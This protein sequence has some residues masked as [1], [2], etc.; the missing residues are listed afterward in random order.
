MNNIIS[1]CN[2]SGNGK[3]GCNT[4]QAQP[5]PTKS[6]QL[7][8]LVSTGKPLTFSVPFLD[9]YISKYLSAY[10]KLDSPALIGTPTAPIVYDVYDDSNQIATTAFVQTVA[11]HTYDTA[12]MSPVF[13]GTITLAPDSLLSVQ[14]RIALSSTAS[15]SLYLNSETDDPLEIYPIKWLY[16]NR[17]TSDVQTQF[18]QQTAASDAI[19]AN[20]IVNQQQLYNQYGNTVI[21]QNNVVYLQGEIDALYGNIQVNQSGIASLYGNASVLQVQTTGQTY[22]S[23]NRQTGFAGNLIVQQNAAVVGATTLTGNVTATTNLVVGGALWGNQLPVTSTQIGYLTNV[24]ADVQGQLNQLGANT[25]TQTYDPA[26]QTTQFSR[27]V[28]VLGNVDVVG[29][30][31]LTGN[32]TATT[33]LVVGGALWGNQLPVTSTQIGY[34]TNVAADVQGQLNQLGANTTTQTYDP[35]SQTTQF[36]RN[37]SVLGNVAVAGN[38][39][40]VSGATTLTGNVTAT[41]NLVVG[42][43]LWGNQL[44]VTS[45]QIG[46]LTGLTSDVQ[47]QLTVL[48]TKTA[49]Q[50]YDVGTTT[51]TF[52]HHVVTGG[53]VHVGGNVQMDRNVVV[54]GGWTVTSTGQATLNATVYLN[55]SIVANSQ[56]VTSTQMGYLSGL[57]SDAQTQMNATALATTRQTHNL[58]TQTTTWTGVNVTVASADVNGNIGGGFVVQRL[59]NSSTQYGDT[60]A[61]TMGT[62]TRNCALGGYALYGLANGSGSYN[63]AV[64]SSSASD[65]IDGVGGTM[66]LLTNGSYNTATGFGVLK[67]ISGTASYNT[68]VGALAFRLAGSSSQYNTGIGY[69]AGTG[70][71]TLTGTQNT[72]LGANSGYIGDGATATSSTA[73]GYGATIQASH[74]IVLGTSAEYVD[75]A[76]NLVVRNES[77]LQKVASVVSYPTYQSLAPNIG[78]YVDY[79]SAASSSRCWINAAINNLSGGIGISMYIDQLPVT[80]NSSYDLRMIID[81]D[82]YVNALYVRFAGSTGAYLPGTLYKNTFSMTSATR[83]NQYIHIVVG[84]TAGT[85]GISYTDITPLTA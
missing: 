68:G 18:S 42:G 41:T 22:V 9:N 76:G 1:Y 39:L 35:V 64:G 46:Y 12:M 48:S 51:T 65:I 20:V 67:L 31:T 10:A 24:A 74:Q 52:G 28:S 19:Y 3:Q 37:I 73:I 62:G 44:P 27:N 30:T 38:Q 36:A 53:D 4:T 85:V 17:V 78:F 8:T 61:T 75:V 25:I 50:T 34:L 56:T 66:G 69:M 79:T 7:A 29:A 2:G 80:A 33:N 43:A 5:A 82:C 49:D 70:S 40:D 59:P 15:S 13:T 32:V 72:F 45:T 84:T 47:S 16:L 55:A 63:V 57:T 81:S 54:G 60:N 23:A 26:S 71:T 21:L 77:R 58:A 14:G 6:V 11:Q 83:V